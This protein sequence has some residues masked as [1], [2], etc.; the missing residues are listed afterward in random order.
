MTSHCACA[1]P[2]S[3]LSCSINKP[4]LSSCCLNT[5][6]LVAYIQTPATIFLYQMDKYSFDKNLLFRYVISQFA[7]AQLLSTY[8]ILYSTF[9]FIAQYLSFCLKHHKAVYTLRLNSVYDGPT[10]ILFIASQSL[11]FEFRTH[12][13][14]SRAYVHYFSFL[15]LFVKFHNSCQGISNVPH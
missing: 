5:V 13:S 15:F 6:C 14:A 4:V 7:C 1:H 11:R 12:P 9:S 10:I 8:L 3:S 2:Y